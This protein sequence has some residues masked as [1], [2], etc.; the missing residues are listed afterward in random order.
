MIS[1]TIEE[2]LDKEIVLNGQGIKVLSLFFV[3]AVANYRKYDEDGNQ[4]NGDYASIF[5]EEYTK[6]IRKPKYQNLFNELHDNELDASLVHNGYFSIDKKSKKSNSKEKF[7]YFKDTKGTTKADEDTYS[8]IM[9]DKEK[10]L[11]FDSKLRFIF[12]HSALKEG[13][14][15]PNVFQICTLRDL[16]GSAITPRQQIGRGLR[17][18]VNQDGER[19]YGHEVNTLSVMATTSYFDFVDTLQKE[20]ESDTGIK[21]GVLEV[22]SFSDIVIGIADGHTTFLGQEKSNEL[23]KHFTA[24]GYLDSRGKVQDLLRIALKEHH[25]DIPEAFTENPHVFKQ[26]IAILKSAAGKL[27]I[28]NKEDKKRVKVNQQI[29]DS[30]AF[31]ELWDRVK[32]KTTFSVTFDSNCADQRMY[33]FYK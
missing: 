22:A 29:L 12:S 26:M 27:E 25:V 31:K 19:V 14:D 1:K 24:K 32:F 17:L 10:L 16:G 18:C 15:N 11:S 3:D 28:K 5:E 33:S 30:P 6:L 7:E 23:Y 9:R 4:I 21:F 13:W 2:H 20:I 8:L